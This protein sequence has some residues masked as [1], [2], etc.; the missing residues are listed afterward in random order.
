MPQLP[1][2]QRAGERALGALLSPGVGLVQLLARACCHPALSL[3][4]VTAIDLSAAVL[5]NTCIIHYRHQEFSHWLG[6]LA[7]ERRCRAVPVPS[8]EHKGR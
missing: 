6:L 8:Q 2:D 1:E 3:L 4:Q 7:Q 5:L